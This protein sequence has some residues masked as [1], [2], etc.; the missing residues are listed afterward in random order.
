MVY[1]V[2]RGPRSVVLTIALSACA[3][4][5]SVPMYDDIG[6]RLSGVLSGTIVQTNECFA[7][8]RRDSR[9]PVLLVL[10]RGTRLHRYGFTLPERNGGKSFSAGEQVTVQG[11]Y[12]EITNSPAGEFRDP[13]CKGEAFIVNHVDYL[14]QQ[15]PGAR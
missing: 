8:D 3:V 1:A 4:N 15:R 9:P 12:T 10:P 5:S 13:G 14:A 7:V 11:G 2:R 6:I